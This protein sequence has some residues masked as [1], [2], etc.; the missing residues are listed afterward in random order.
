MLTNFCQTPVLGLGLGVEFTFA[1]DKNN[2]DNNNND[3]KNKNPHLNFQKIHSLDKGKWLRE[4][5]KLEPSSKLGIRATAKGL[6]GV[7][8]W[9]ASLVY[10]SNHHELF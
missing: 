8:H 6:G 3:N 7:W 1:W 4:A 10:P 2:N 9:R 5:S